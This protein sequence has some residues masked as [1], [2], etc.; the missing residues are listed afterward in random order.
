[1]IIYNYDKDTGEFLNAKKARVNPKKLSDY[2]TPAFATEQKPPEVEGNKIV[3]FDKDLNGWKIEDD[4]RG[5][6]YFD[7]NTG[8]RFVIEKIGEKLKSNAV[9]TEPPIEFFE[10]KYQGKKWVE[11]AKVYKGKKANNSKEVDNIARKE[12][13]DLDPFPIMISTINA[14]V[15]GEGVP[16]DWTALHEAITEI[17]N[18]ADTYKSNNK[19]NKGK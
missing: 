4:Y 13:N 5:L 8:E 1:M 9:T 19:I 10:P 6:A 15:M 17:Y 18:E 12:I 2:L 14:L 7:K 16:Q 11:K 3:I